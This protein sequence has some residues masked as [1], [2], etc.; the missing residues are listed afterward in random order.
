MHAAKLFK[1]MTLKMEVFV[2]FF[3]ISAGFEVLTV[4]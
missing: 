4:I 2:K 1:F 3:V